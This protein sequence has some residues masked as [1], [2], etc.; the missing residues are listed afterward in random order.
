MELSAP[1]HVLKKQAKEL[2]KAKSMT[3]VEALN[4][5]ATQEG[6]SDEWIEKRVRDIAVRDELTNEW[7]KRG[8]KE[9]TE[10]SILTAEKV[11]LLAGD[12]RI[13]EMTAAI[14]YPYETSMAVSWI[15][16]HQRE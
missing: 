2:K 4:H 6:Y 14:P 1:I 15:Q 8:V 10:Y 13:V 3:M 7:K 16:N 12:I 5:V 9:R 11:A